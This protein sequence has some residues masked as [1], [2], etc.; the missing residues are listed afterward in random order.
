MG[1]QRATNIVLTL[2]H[3]GQKN[4]STLGPLIHNPQSIRL[5]ESKGVRVIENIQD[6][7]SE[8]GII[9]IRAHGIPPETRKEMQR[10]KLL[11]RDATCPKVIKVQSIIKTHV[12]NG[13]QAIIVGDKEHPEVKGLL[14]F[15]GAGG[16]AVNL[17]DELKNLPG[18]GKI[19]VVAQTT[20]NEEK[21][22]EIS[23]Q[24]K[25]KARECLIYNTICDSTNKR[26]AEIKELSESSDLLVIIGGRNSGNTQRLAEIARKTGKR[27]VLIESEEEIDAAA[28]VDCKTIGV[29]AGASTPAWVIERVIHK[30]RQ[31]GGAGN[32][33]TD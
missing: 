9:V 16:Y 3:K 26:Q 21:F 1:V 33:K 29:S 27:T 19:C 22:L 11:I 2:I 13:Y 28:L 8:D 5:L 18:L 12:N 7:L 14:G 6:N 25:E 23:Q 15:A 32:E 30:I 17:L 24:L 31:L 4:I 10:R 20:Q